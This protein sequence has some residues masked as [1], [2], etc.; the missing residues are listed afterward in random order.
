MM[1]AMV[2]SRAMRSAVSGWVVTASHSSILAGL[3]CSRRQGDASRWW[4]G[5]LPLVRI[6]RTMVREQARSPALG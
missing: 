6:A 5:H 1:C 3:Q 2:C 4:R